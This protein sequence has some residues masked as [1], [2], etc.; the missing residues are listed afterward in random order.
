MSI[1][2]MNMNSYEI[3]RHETSP[4]NYSDEVLSVGWIPSLAQQEVLAQQ[5]ENR[6]SIP[7][8]LA[9]VDASAFL[10]KMYKNQR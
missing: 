5:W 8:D 4:D 9:N 7:A 10:R 6:A 2:T 1:L 3:H